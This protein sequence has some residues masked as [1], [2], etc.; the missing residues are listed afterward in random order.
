MGDQFIRFGRSVVVL[1]LSEPER[2]VS[3]SFN[4][5]VDVAQSVRICEIKASLL[6]KFTFR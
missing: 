6:E 3:T 1:D 5:G 4:K 2:R